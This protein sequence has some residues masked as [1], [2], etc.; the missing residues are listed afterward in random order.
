MSERTQSGLATLA[1]STVLLSLVLYPVSY[2]VLVKPHP[3]YLR[4]V[5]L[6]GVPT[7]ERCADYRLGGAVAESIFAPLES[8]DRRLRPAYW[9]GADLQPP[10]IY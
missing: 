1:V 7:L 3:V 10:F 4:T 6:S 2:A 9:E 8:L 5:S